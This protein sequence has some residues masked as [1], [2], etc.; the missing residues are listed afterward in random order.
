MKNSTND[1]V[2]R[3]EGI[4]VFLFLFLLCKIWCDLILLRDLQ[5]E[6]IFSKEFKF[7]YFRYEKRKK[8]GNS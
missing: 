7:E 4:A 2:C 3:A 1:I 5:V 8:L 6:K